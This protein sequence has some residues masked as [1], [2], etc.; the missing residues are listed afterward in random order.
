MLADAGVD[1]MIAE[2]MAGDSVIDDPISDCATAVK[3]CASSG[4]P[5]FLGLCGVTQ[6]GT[7]YDGDLSATSSR[8]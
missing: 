4:L 3:A 5:A 7:L 8:R 6:S 1:F 2:Y